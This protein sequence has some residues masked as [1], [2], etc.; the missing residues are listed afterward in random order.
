MHA[1]LPRHGGGVWHRRL[2][3]RAC[4]THCARR[5]KG[6]AA[7][8]AAAGGAGDPVALHLF[9]EVRRSGY[10]QPVTVGARAQ[11]EA[12]SSRAIFHSSS[13]RRAQLTPRRLTTAT[14]ATHACT[15]SQSLRT[16]PQSR[17]AKTT[18]L[19]I[20]LLL[21]GDALLKAIF[22]R[23]TTDATIEVALAQ[24]YLSSRDAYASGGNGFDFQ[25]IFLP[26]F[27]AM[28]ERG[29]PFV[30]AANVLVR[31]RIFGQ[32]FYAPPHAVDM[33]P[34]ASCTQDARGE[35]IGP[36]AGPVC[37]ALDGAEY[38]A[39]GNGPATAVARLMDWQEGGM[40]P[41]STPCSDSGC[42]PFSFDAGDY[43]GWLDLARSDSATQHRPLP[44]KAF[45]PPYEDAS[46]F[47]P[48]CSD[49][50]VFQDPTASYKYCPWS[51]YHL[52]VDEMFPVLLYADGTT[53]SVSE[54]FNA[55][56]ESNIQSISNNNKTV[57]AELWYTKRPLRSVEAVLSVL[58]TL[59]VCAV[60]GAVSFLLSRDAE[61][62]SSYTL[63]ASAVW[64]PP[65][66]TARNA[67]EPRIFLRIAPFFALAA[68]ASP[69]LPDGDPADRKDGGRGDPASSQSGL[70][71]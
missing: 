35:P 28:F 60:L 23:P 54:G 26:A 53:N 63:L 21:C 18:V 1:A 43:P 19:F 20:L 34:L 57:V 51:V 15:S 8:A 65:R 29:F 12:A 30:G 10:V 46:P 59:V 69:L 47:Y 49:Y 44:A 56:L 7:A 11:S 33:P 41:A 5:H 71:A 32:T 61:Q 64:P 70:Q 48:L 40:F 55:A 38:G 9:R 39:A 3:R 66:P 58:F 13:T 22:E 31:L 4:R 17:I 45:P 27:L 6:R 68:T 36:Y 16:R 42:Y 52:R 67:A 2:G 50:S 25:R 14:H 24:L 62:A 37:R